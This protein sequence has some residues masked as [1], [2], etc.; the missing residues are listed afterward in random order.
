MCMC[1][2]FTLPSNKLVLKTYYYPFLISKAIKECFFDGA[3]H[4][5][6]I[7]FLLHTILAVLAHPFPLIHMTFLDA[8]HRSYSNA[9][10]PTE[11]Q[12][13]P[14]RS[15]FCRSPRMIEVAMYRTARYL[16]LLVRF[17]SWWFNNFCSGI[18]RCS[19]TPAAKPIA[20]PGLLTI[21]ASSQ[22]RPPHNLGLLTPRRLPQLIKV[23]TLPHQAQQPHSHH[24][25]HCGLVS[26]CFSVAHLLRIP[27]V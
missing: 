4:V 27:T 20:R 22:S 8:F 21:S 18:V 15:T 11:F 2:M 12:Q 25:F 1:G 26:C 10:G 16:F 24:P 13:R 23:L 9:D 14:W 17:P 7:L 3:Q 19:A 6:A 5:V